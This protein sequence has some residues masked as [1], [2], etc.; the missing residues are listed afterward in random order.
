MWKPVPFVI[1]RYNDEAPKDWN[2]YHSGRKGVLLV[3][4]W[5]R[6]LLIDLNEQ[7]VYDIDP[8]KIK[9]LGENVEW[10]LADVP[11]YVVNISEWKSR[12]AGPVQRIRFRFGASGSFVEIQVPLKADGKPAY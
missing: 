2:V 4:L 3:R 8:Q 7:E 1:V 5:K 10:S 9:A 12:N 6:Y 11:D